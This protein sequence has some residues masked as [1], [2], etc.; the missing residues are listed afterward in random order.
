LGTLAAFIRLSSATAPERKQVFR[1]ENSS[2]SMRTKEDSK[3]W[4]KSWKV[5]FFAFFL[6]AWK[7]Y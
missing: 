1:D 2:G 4:K 3:P 7:Q 5:T 6:T